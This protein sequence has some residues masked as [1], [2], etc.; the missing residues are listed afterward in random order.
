MQ[1]LSCG[2]LGALRVGGGPDHQ[3][4]RHFFI[5]HTPTVDADLP[6]NRRP[7]CRV[8]PPRTGESRPFCPRIVPSLRQDS[9]VTK[10]TPKEQKRRPRL[11]GGILIG[12]AFLL[13]IAL[14]FV[15]GEGAGVTVA[16]VLVLVAGALQFGGALLLDKSGRA[17]PTHAKAAVSRL[18][19]LASQAKRARLRA[20]HAFET[21]TGAPLKS[22]AGQLNVDLS[23]I[24]EGIALAAQDW[25]LFHPDAIQKLDEEDQR[26]G[27]GG[28][29]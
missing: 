26:P 15:P 24:E 12:V 7:T 3:R 2:I 5:T 9:A 27:E 4:D 8:I 17:D 20:E 21:Q 25:A 19:L 1:C 28:R 14:A 18:V 10:A 13:T 23:Y 11:A 22:S 16:V 29:V 6:R